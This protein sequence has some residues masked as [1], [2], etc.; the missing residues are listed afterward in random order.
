MNSILHNF[1]LASSLVAQEW[2]RQIFIKDWIRK[3]NQVFFQKLFSSSIH[4]RVELCKK[5]E[6]KRSWSVAGCDRRLLSL[7][8][9]FH[10]IKEQCEVDLKISHEQKLWNWT[11]TLSFRRERG[12]ST[13]Y[14]SFKYISSCSNVSWRTPIDSIEEKVKTRGSLS[15]VPEFRQLL[16]NLLFCTRTSL[17]WIHK[18][19]IQ[20][21]CQFLLISNF[22][23][24]SSIQFNEQ[25]TAEMRVEKPETVL[26]KWVEWND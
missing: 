5:W 23:C 11:N 16:S 2:W 3:K 15:G 18:K 1:S 9:D 22:F 26:F 19:R 24:F 14:F 17:I 7:C 13:N 25:A 12:W 20:K 8:V 21:D 6:K 10:G 4:E